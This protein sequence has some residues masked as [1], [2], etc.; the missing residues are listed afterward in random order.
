[1][2]R[3]AIA[4]GCSLFFGLGDAVE[5]A[6]S[7]FYKP[8]WWT[9]C[10]YCRSCGDVGAGGRMAGKSVFRRPDGPHLCPDLWFVCLFFSS[11]HDP[12]I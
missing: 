12:A 8:T 6:S 11:A 10:M 7:P 5:V 2:D 3:R 1:M 9:A 4:R